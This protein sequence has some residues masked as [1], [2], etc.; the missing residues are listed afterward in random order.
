MATPTFLLAAIDLI[1][2]KVA[3]S[4]IV[5]AG[6]ADIALVETHHE[7]AVVAAVGRVAI[8]EEIFV[9]RRLPVD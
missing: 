5:E 6:I 9:M 3:R 4:A 7:I 2:G 8:A 1:I